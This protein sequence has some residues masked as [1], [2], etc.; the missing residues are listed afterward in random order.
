MRTGWTRWN[1]LTGTSRYPKESPRV[2]LSVEPVPLHGPGP[3]RGQGPGGPV[4]WAVEVFV[5][6]RSQ[7]LGGRLVEVIA[8]NA[9]DCSAGRAAVE[10]AYRA[11][12]DAT[13]AGRPVVPSQ[14][15][16]QQDGPEAHRTTERTGGAAS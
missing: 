7:P 13:R 8:G 11:T 9:G 5:T 15:S 2:I 3:G 14:V 4:R 10:L 12:D 1:R 6:D 16:D